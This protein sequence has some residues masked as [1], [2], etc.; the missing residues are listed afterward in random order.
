MEQAIANLPYDEG[1]KDLSVQDLVWAHTVSTNHRLEHSTYDD[2][3][4]FTG[5]LRG[6]LRDQKGSEGRNSVLEEAM[7]YLVCVGVFG[8]SVLQTDGCKDSFSLCFLIQRR[9][10]KV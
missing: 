3:P 1:F 7:R 5:L 8:P 2:I 6:G 4:S 9:L 10:R